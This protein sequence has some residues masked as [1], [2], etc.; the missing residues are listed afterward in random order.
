[1]DDKKIKMSL[2][3]RAIVSFF[4]LA[5]IVVCVIAGC[6]TKKTIDSITTSPEVD[7]TEK[8]TATPTPTPT[9]IMIPTEVPPTPEPTV[10]TVTTEVAPDFPVPTS[11]YGD[12]MEEHLKNQNMKGE[13]NN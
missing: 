8:P 13:N 5:I 12:S 3:G 6:D 10:E 11:G 4:I 2:I 7:S 1:M 9:Q